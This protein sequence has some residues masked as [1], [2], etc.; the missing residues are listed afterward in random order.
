LFIA[1]FA[2]AILVKKVYRPWVYQHGAGFL[3]VADWGP[4][5]FYIFGFIMLTAFLIAVTGR[6]RPLKFPL[7][8][9]I[10]IGAMLYEISHAFRSDSWSS[11]DDLIATIVGGLVAMFVEG[12]LIRTETLRIG[13]L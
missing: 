5:L 11:W 7:M 13:I 4:N 2:L 10:A 3:P 9:G 8:A 12:I 1:S 6:M